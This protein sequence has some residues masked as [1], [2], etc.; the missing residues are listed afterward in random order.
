MSLSKSDSASP[1]YPDE[2]EE[3]ESDPFPTERSSGISLMSEGDRRRLLIL[4]SLFHASLDPKC[5][6]MNHH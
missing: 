1:P 3:S 4:S 5:Q 6:P 2:L